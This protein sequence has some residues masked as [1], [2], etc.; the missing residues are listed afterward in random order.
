MRIFLSIKDEEEYEDCV[1]VKWDYYVYRGPS[2]LILSYS[3]NGPHE[4]RIEP[5]T[6][7][8]CWYGGKYPSF[9]FDQHC[10]SVMTNLR[11]TINSELRL[12][13]KPL[14]ALEQLAII[15]TTK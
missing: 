14:S 9:E 7:V 15:G 10:Q 8:R 4:F 3:P 13:F 1:F 2:K 6:F 11:F 5:G 12:S